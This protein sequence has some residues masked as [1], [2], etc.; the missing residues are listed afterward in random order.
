MTENRNYQEIQASWNRRIN[1]NGC[2]FFT[3]FALFLVLLCVYAPGCSDFRDGAMI[4]IIVLL[5]LFFSGA[6]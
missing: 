1:R 5:N 4:I 3:G 6:I 2:F